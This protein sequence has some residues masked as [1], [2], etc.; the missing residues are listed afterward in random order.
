MLGL[1]SRS[2]PIG[3]SWPSVIWAA[4]ARGSWVSSFSTSFRRRAQV[5]SMY[6]PI[7]YGEQSSDPIWRDLLSL[8]GRK[9]PSGIYAEITTVIDPS[10]RPGFVTCERAA[11][12]SFVWVATR[13]APSVG[14]WEEMGFGRA[15]LDLYEPIPAPWG[16]RAQSISSGLQPDRPRPSIAPLRDTESK[17]SEIPS[18]CQESNCD[19]AS[20]DESDRRSGKQSSSHIS[21]VA[22][23]A[24]ISDTPSANI[25]LEEPTLPTKDLPKG[26]DQGREAP[27]RV[28]RKVAI[29]RFRANAW[30]ILGQRVRNR[31]TRRPRRSWK[32]SLYRKRKDSL[33]GRHS[34]IERISGR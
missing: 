34:G 12:F 10:W 20:G 31:S 25:Q 1:D 4:N 6:R 22:E 24:A 13:S 15:L 30:S 21:Q 2:L 11:E 19:L 9:R 29:D 33:Y 28:R 32:R 26:H 7:K 27:L 14:K 16:N 5:E 18:R 23:M 3:R 17:L 8:S